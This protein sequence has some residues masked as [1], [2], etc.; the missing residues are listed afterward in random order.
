VIREDRSVSQELLDR[1]AC[2]SGSDVMFT[3]GA[4]YKTAL[5]EINGLCRNL[6]ASP[7][8][9]PVLR[10][11]NSTRDSFAGNLSAE[12]RRSSFSHTDKELEVPCVFFKEFPLREVGEPV[13]HIRLLHAHNFCIRVVSTS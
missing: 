2:S 8:T 1:T 7:S 12:E 13:D 3:S 11:Q 5:E 4:E 10:C 9:A 6:S